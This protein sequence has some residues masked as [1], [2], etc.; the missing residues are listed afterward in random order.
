MLDDE[1]I[2]RHLREEPETEAVVWALIEAA[3]AAGGLDNTTV[4]VVDVRT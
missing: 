1:Q 3:N 4:A 2:A